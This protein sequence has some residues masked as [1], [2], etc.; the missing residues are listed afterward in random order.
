MRSPR[1]TERVT[2]VVAAICIGAALTGPAVAAADIVTDSPS[3]AGD[4]GGSL[5]GNS[6]GSFG[7]RTPSLPSLGIPGVT[8][9]PTSG[10]H[11]DRPTS[12]GPS[13]DNRPEAR[14][15]NGRP[16]PSYSS[17]KPAPA[18]GP[19]PGPV[20]VVPRFPVLVGCE[21]FLC[22]PPGNGEG[23]QGQPEGQ[24][25]G[26]PTPP[27]VSEV[28]DP[29]PQDPLEPKGPPAG[30]PE[31]VPVDVTAGPADKVP[32]AVEAPASVSVEVPAAPLEAGPQAA[33]IKLTSAV[34]NGTVALTLILIVLISGVWFY[35][36]RLGSR[37]S[38]R[39]NNHA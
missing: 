11:S 32:A 38:N 16:S 31:A 37:L 17:P 29:G 9:G 8:L 4:S 27:P 6:T 19:Q 15:G 22:A 39:R 25:E 35:A 14:F 3:P 7:S 2:T 18:A 13:G 30:T 28:P 5:G 23:P 1:G 26:Q 10:G 34:G 33:A 24:P 20:D 21:F 36:N 12:V